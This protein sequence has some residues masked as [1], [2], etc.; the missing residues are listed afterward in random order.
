MHRLMLLRHAKTDRPAGVRDVDRPLA[1]RG[2]RA[3]PRMGAYLAEAGLIPDLALVSPA[4]RAG[5]TWDLA[6]PPLGAV[7]E[8]SEPRLYEASVET[9]L[10][11]VRETDPG[12]KTLLM[13]G[14]NPGFEKLAV[15][16]VG[17]G[18][19]AARA[20]LADKFPTAAVAVIDFAIEDWRAVAPG[21]GRLE[22]F[23]TPRALESDGD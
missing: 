6:K 13:V 12:V 22:R 16:L 7:P 9:L 4:Q 20:R 19:A 1:R 23:V 10:A 14:H 5:Q 8:Q 2:R 18:E 21:S 17:E 15:H 3:S 11:I